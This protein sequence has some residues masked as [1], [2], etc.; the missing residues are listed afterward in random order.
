M[1]QDEPLSASEYTLKNSP[2]DL[3]SRGWQARYEQGKTGWDRGQPN[4]ILEQWLSSNALTPG[5]VLIPGCGRGHEVIRLAEAGFDVTGIDF[6]PAAVEHLSKELKHRSLQAEIIEANILE[7]EPESRFDN[8]YE[9]T[10]LCALEPKH[11]PSYETK[12]YQWLKPKGR[13]LILFMQCEKRNEPPY[14]C[15]LDQMQNL[16]CRTRWSWQA[17]EPIRV[18][19]PLGFHELACLLTRNEV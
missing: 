13:L 18:E 17:E 9:Q 11:W 3:S 4:S 5:R 16:F 19:H 12:L 15:N 7:Y 1:P 10:C 6:A 2:V 14:V 8:I